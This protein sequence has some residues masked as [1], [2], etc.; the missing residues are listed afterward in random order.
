MKGS[1]VRVVFSIIQ[2]SYNTFSFGIARLRSKFWGVFT[3]KMGQRVNIKSGTIIFSPFHVE[4]G[5]FCDF[6]SNCN[7]NGHSGLTIGSFVR[8]AG[9]V[10]VLTNQYIYDDPKLPVYFS[11]Y[12]PGPVVI[13]DDVWVG[14]NAVIMP[15]VTI[16]RGA[17]VGANAV[18]TKS[19]EPY[20]IVGGV[21][22]KRIRYR[23][24]PEERKQAMQLDLKSFKRK[25][26][27]H[28]PG[29]DKSI[30]FF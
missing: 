21:P 4:I 13:E 19:V 11:G 16:G 7:L 3:K 1:A 29:D 14:V 20:A 25:D 12:H 27:P 23:F 2:Y 9:N 6:G 18:V 10:S 5:D 15:G 22:A 8:F 26:H 30:P 17:I 24:G 28:H